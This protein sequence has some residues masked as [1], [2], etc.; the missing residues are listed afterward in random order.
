MLKVKQ[1]Q[2]TE[3]DWSDCEK[4]LRRFNL[5]YR[6]LLGTNPFDS[7]GIYQAA[8]ETIGEKGPSVL[9]SYSSQPFARR[10]RHYIPLIKSRADLT[11]SLDSV[12]NVTSNIKVSYLRGDMPKV[13]GYFDSLVKV[14][15]AYKGTLQKYVDLL[16]PGPSSFQWKGFKINNPEGVP[17]AVIYPILDGIHEGL[18]IFKERGVSEFLYQNLSQITLSPTLE[19]TESMEVHGWY[20]PSRKEIEV[21]TYT[22]DHARSRLY[23]RWVTEIFIH[24]FG[25]HIHLSNLP[26][27]AKEFWDSGWQF[28]DEAEKSSRTR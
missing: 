28:I 25:H 15:K 10:V 18:A 24:E 4:D 6:D 21:K 14:V 22:L 11:E 26:R 8:L 9:P 20:F 12:T 2:V 17:D 3:P 16:A 19:K 13:L 1:S 5:W 27:A 23:S 7:E